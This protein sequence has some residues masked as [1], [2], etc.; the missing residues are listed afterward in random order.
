MN[1]ISRYLKFVFWIVICSWFILATIRTIYNF[2]KVFT[3]EKDWIFLTEDQKRQ[4]IFGDLNSFLKFVEKNTSPNSSI[5][6][7]GP[8]GKSY[9]LGRYYLYPRRLV[10]ITNPKE[11]ENVIKN[12]SYTYFL[13]YQTNDPALNENKSLAWNVV[14]GKE[15]AH[16]SSLNNYKSLGT[17]FKL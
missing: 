13:T 15:I 10:Y 5:L 1:K 2:S 16:Y 14:K 11:I 8:G 3:E 4:K 6:F 7:L 17:L 9:Y 12:C